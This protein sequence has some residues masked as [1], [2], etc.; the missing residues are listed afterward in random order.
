MT[1]IRTTPALAAS[2][3][4]LLTLVGCGSTG[5][6]GSQSSSDTPKIPTATVDGVTVPTASPDPGDFVDTVDNPYFPLDPGTV[7]IS[8]SDGDDGP[9]KDVVTVTDKTRVIQGV[10]TVVVHDVVRD[11]TGKLVEDTY[12]WYAQDRDGNVWYF[13]EDTTAYDSGKPDTE[14][15]W[16]AGRD[17]ARAGIAMLAHPDVGDAY[18]QE[19]RH[20]VAEDHGKVLSVTARVTGPT[21]AYGGVLKTED[22]TPLEPNLVEHKYYARG[23]GVVAEETVAGGHEQVRL[24]GI[25]RP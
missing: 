20:D 8:T 13:G 15:S 24:V 18:A 22:I 11:D 2:G 25:R 9:Q 23:I 16:E 19:Y 7:W 1:T 5:T 17:D 3:L 6:T 10:T 12:D 21:G 4:L 14:G